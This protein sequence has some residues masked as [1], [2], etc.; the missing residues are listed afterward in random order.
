MAYIPTGMQAMFPIYLGRM[1]Q[2]GEDRD[3]YDSSVAQNENNLNQNF[4]I[5]F[6]KIAELESA[7]ADLTEG[8]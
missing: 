7:L 5:L 4:A 3:A 2:D 1:P 6:D 8:G